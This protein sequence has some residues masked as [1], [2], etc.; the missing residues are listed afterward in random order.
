MFFSR[1]ENIEYDDRAIKD[2]SIALVIKPE[3]KD[4]K[5]LFFFYEVEDWETPESVAF[6]YYGNTKYNYVILLMN[7]IVDPFWDWHLSQDELRRYCEDKYGTPTITAGKYNTDG[8]FAVRHWEYEG[9]IYFAEPESGDGQAPVTA[10]AVSHFE[11]EERKN[12]AKRKIKIL[13]PEF[14]SNINRELDFILND[15]TSTNS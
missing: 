2:L 6:D 7:D 4:N 5:D 11:Y 9:I 14:I 3:I 12:D 1:F 8:Y 15:A 13:Y 10:L